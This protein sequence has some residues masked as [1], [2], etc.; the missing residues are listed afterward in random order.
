MRQAAKAISGHYGQ[1]VDGCNEV[2]R[3]VRQR[4]LRCQS[5][6]WPRLPSI[7]EMKRDNE[8]PYPYFCKN[9]VIWKLAMRPWLKFGS[10]LQPSVQVPNSKH[11]PTFMGRSKVQV[12]NYKVQL[13]DTRTLLPRLLFMLQPQ[14]ASVCPPLVLFRSHRRHPHGAGCAAMRAK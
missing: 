1:Q 5:S 9:D 6:P 14:P 4:F 3:A 7:F 10:V 12:L 2:W 11:V 13:Q 8:Q